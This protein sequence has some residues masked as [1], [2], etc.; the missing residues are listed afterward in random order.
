MHLTA[1]D[2]DVGLKNIWADY[3][4]MRA[5]DVLAPQIMFPKAE[6]SMSLADTTQLLMK[7]SDLITALRY[8]CWWSECNLQGE[9]PLSYLPHVGPPSEIVSI[10]DGTAALPIRDGKMKIRQALVDRLGFVQ[11]MAVGRTFPYPPAVPGGASLWFQNF[12]H[13]PWIFDGFV[14]NPMN[15]WSALSGFE[16]GVVD[17]APMPPALP[18]SLFN[19]LP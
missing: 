18:N 6:D 17:A 2:G 11:K 13:H 9:D 15:P 14:A 4:Y 5:F 16:F 1:V 10:P 12:E 3:G 7:N 8:G 19:P